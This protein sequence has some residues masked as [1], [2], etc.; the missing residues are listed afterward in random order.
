[1]SN[2]TTGR[3]RA[4]RPIINNNSDSRGFAAAEQTLS[5]KSM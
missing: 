5:G 1:M 2:R 3:G 4:I